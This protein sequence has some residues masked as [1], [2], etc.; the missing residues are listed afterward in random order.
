MDFLVG[1]KRS[2]QSRCTKWF[3][4]QPARENAAVLKPK[5]L[6]RSGLGLGEGH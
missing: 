5:A 4:N 2:L 1:Y 3:P 6:L